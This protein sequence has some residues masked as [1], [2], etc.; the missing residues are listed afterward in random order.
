M[1][2]K[3][4]NNMKIWLFIIFNV[5]FVFCFS[6]K[7]DFLDHSGHIDSSFQKFIYD[8]DTSIKVEKV[9]WREDF[10]PMFSITLDSI[11]TTLFYVTFD[12]K[13]VIGMSQ[14]LLS[15]K[16]W[17]HSSSVNVVVYNRIDGFLYVFIHSKEEFINCRERIPIIDYLSYIKMVFVFNSTRDYV[18]VFSFNFDIPN[19][20]TYY[21]IIYCIDSVRYKETCTAR[22]IDMYFGNQYKFF[23]YYGFKSFLDMLSTMMINVQ[24]ENCILR[25]YSGGNHL[26][27]KKIENKNNCNR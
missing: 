7:G 5:I 26:I 22:G 6:Q 18:G 14:N 15:N 4:N 2:L 9:L 25:E 12:D 8:I 11:N 20:Q 13:Y 24:N 23:T 17:H 21:S 27:I 3:N 1:N 19:Y 10:F 16:S